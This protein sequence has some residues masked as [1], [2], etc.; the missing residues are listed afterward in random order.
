MQDKITTITK[1]KYLQIAGLLTLAQFHKN[2]VDECEKIMSL[3][4]EEGEDCGHCGDA[5]WSDYTA[6]ILLEKL[7]I[8]VDYQDG[9][10]IS[11]NPF[12]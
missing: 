12:V 7:N 9:L 8:K 3:M 1:E 6:D 10:N 11:T 2:R 4:I 5:I